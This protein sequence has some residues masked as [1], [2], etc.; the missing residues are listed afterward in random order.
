MN[1]CF[2]SQEFP[3]D[4]GWGGIG[5]YVYNISRGLAEIG[6]HVDVITRATT[7]DGMVISYEGRLRVH[8]VWQKDYPWLRQK[9]LAY[10]NWYHHLHHLLDRPLGWGYGA[11]KHVQR[12]LRERPVDIIE[13]PEHNADGFVY[14]ARRLSNIFAPRQIHPRFVVKL[15]IPIMY[16]YQLNG[17]KIRVDIRVLNQLERWT[18]RHADCITSPSRKLAEIVAE[19]WQLNPKTIDILPHPIDDDVFTPAPFLRR[20]RQTILFVG[21]LEK[22]K[23]IEVLIEAF[24]AV[25]AQCPQ[26]TL[27]LIGADAGA[28]KGDLQKKLQEYRLDSAVQL[29]GKVVREHLPQYYQQSTICVVPSEFESFSYVCVEAMACGRPVVASRSGGVPEIIADGKNG[30]LVPPDNP[31]ALADAMIRLLQQPTLA[32]RIGAEARAYIEQTYART[33][34]ARQTVNF[35]ENLIK[36]AR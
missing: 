2:I 17:F 3:P 29:L 1:I 13:A 20:D 28:D 24:R 7:T 4:T 26:A 34:I 31:H 10:F 22:Q 12:V 11:Y 30:I 36:T 14:L 16:Y 15:H 32:E 9:P 8:R 5:T 27:T 21:R 18:T 23:G 33:V 25:L 35:Y 19:L 6:H